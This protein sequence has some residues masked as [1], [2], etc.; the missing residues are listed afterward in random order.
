MEKRIEKKV[1]V[2]VAWYY[3]ENKELPKGNG[4]WAFFMGK[5][6][7]DASKTLSFTGKFNDAKKFARAKAAELGFGLVTLAA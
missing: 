7:S 1:T 4:T 2:N 5:D 6:M 3:F